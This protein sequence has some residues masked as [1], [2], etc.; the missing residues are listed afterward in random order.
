ME[1]RGAALNRNEP[2]GLL[3]GGL[4][5]DMMDTTRTESPLTDEDIFSAKLTPYRSLPRSGF[6][7]LMVIVT[8]F[9]AGSGILFLTVGAWPIFGFMGLDV[10]L[11]IAAF[12]WSYRSAQAYEEV[13]VSVH[14]VIV[15]KVSASGTRQ[16][17]R[18]NPVWLR[19]E[20]D[21]LEDEG[22][23][24]LRLVGH[25]RPVPIGTFLNPDDKESFAYALKHALFEA[26]HFPVPE[27]W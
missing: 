27:P 2:A 15:E 10:A 16:V 25:G 4:Q 3:G 14:E 1:A 23:V 26:R 7:I 5:E 12:W 11:V 8:G 20:V 6:I 21:R 13:H 19:L 17:W 24:A 9:A 18:L 22:V